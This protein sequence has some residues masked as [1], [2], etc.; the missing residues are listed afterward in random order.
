MMEA[1]MKRKSKQ[2]DDTELALRLGSLLLLCLGGRTGDVLQVIDESGLTFVQMKATMALGTATDGDLPTVTGLAEALG[3]S[4]A[5]ASRAVDDLVKKG[6]LSRVEDSEDRRVRRLRLTDKGQ[7]VADR[8]L[9]ARMA[10]LQEVAASLTPA[11]RKKLEPALD[12]LMKRDE[13][14]EIYETYARKTR[15]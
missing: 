6:L 2:A 8:V 11:E 13:L 12:E 7:D 9:S 5:S 1:A 15:R 3:I 4:P 14:A 10:G